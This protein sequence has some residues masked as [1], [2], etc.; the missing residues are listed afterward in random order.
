M[1]GLSASKSSDFSRPIAPGFLHLWFC[2]VPVEAAP[3]SLSAQVT[4]LSPAERERCQR[5]PEQ[6]RAQALLTRWLVR[7]VLSR[8][9]DVDPA[10]WRFESGENGKPLAACGDQQ[11][12]PFN[13]SHSHGWIACAVAGQGRVGVDVE[14][15]ASSRDYMRMARRYFTLA[16][17]EQLEMLAGAPQQQRFY[18]LWTL[19][20]AWSKARGGNIGSALG[21]VA[22]DLGRPGQIAVTAAD[23]NPGSFWLA[24]P[25]AGVRLA[26]CQQH[27]PATAPELAVFEAIPGVGEA[28]LALPLLATTDGAGG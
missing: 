2:R 17:R 3:D 28:G 27:G 22:F 5:L 26:L 24:E 1:T 25:A 21:A 19:K 14:A 15:W 8:Y 4:I 16:E 23:A 13:L 9:V 11:A 20:E 10:Q 6:N 12:P 18:E 7:T